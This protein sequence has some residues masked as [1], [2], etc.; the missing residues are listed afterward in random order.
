MSV[1]SRNLCNRAAMGLVAFT[2]TLGHVIGP[3]PR[4]EDAA[5]SPAG[6][7]AE[8]TDEASAALQAGEEL[9]DEPV[10]TQ[11]ELEEL[12]A[13]IALYPDPL[14]I[15]VLLASTSPLD[16]V[17]AQRWLEKNPD[18]SD[19]ELIEKAE[20][21]NWDPSIISLVAF[22]TVI[23]RMADNLDWTETLGDAMALQ[24]EDVLAAVQTM[25]ALAQ[26][27]GLLESGEEMTVSQDEDDTIVI[28]PTNPEVVYVPVYEP[29]KVYSAQ[30]TQTTTVVES[31]TSSSGGNTLAA[32]LIGF[33]AGA[34]LTSLYHN[35]RYDY[36]WGPRYRSVDWYDYRIRPPYYRPW[37]GYRP[38]YY[39]PPPPGY[40][41]GTG[42]RPRPELYRD[43]R[44]RNDWRRDT[45]ITVNRNRGVVVNDR[46]R[47]ENRNRARSL[48]RDL[49]RRGKNQGPALGTAKASRLSTA[50]SGQR[51]DR[52]QQKG[53]R[54]ARASAFSG[55]G[56]AQASNKSKQRGKASL[57]AANRGKTDR[58]RTAKSANRGK[59]T[60]AKRQSAQRPKQG[61]Q[62]SKKGAQAAPKQRAKATPRPSGGG[63]A[64]K[65]DGG[66]ASTKASSARGKKS[67][68]GQR[69]G[70]R[71]TD[72]RG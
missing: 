35:D 29:A 66:S 58:A 57:E 59:V 31:S 41:P 21:E 24:S 12:V 8:G 46:G 70:G 62:Q 60:D 54:K 39:R 23:E 68:S 48:E 25:R 38:P 40:Y 36:Y 67:V 64:F 30:P 18:L 15:Q 55:Q 52:G 17:R 26:A 44:Y 37:T 20:Q 51:Q 43:A 65:R 47:A 50:S 22:P 14:L 16:V 45:N 4:A 1:N 32:G 71:R 5:T 7:V 19:E 53:S 9:A 13:P 27:R 10:F 2:L 61:A 69:A 49:Q 63:G 28:E 6:N 34:I 11:E 56:G 72:K 42:W 33:T 3:S